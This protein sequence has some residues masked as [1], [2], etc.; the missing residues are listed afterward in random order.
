MAPPYAPG[1]APPG[2]V[3]GYDLQPSTDPNCP[4]WVAVPRYELEQPPAPEGPG[5]DA[6]RATLP[7][8]HDLTL[9]PPPTREDPAAAPPPVE[10]TLRPVEVGR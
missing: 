1:E 4:G 8:G 10:E 3:S 9:P 6:E 7:A 2:E 5:S